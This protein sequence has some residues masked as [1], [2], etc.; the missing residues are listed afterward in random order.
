MLTAMRGFSFGD[1]SL[2]LNSWIRE[3]ILKFPSDGSKHHR[4]F[5]GCRLVLTTTFF[6]GGTMSQID[7]LF[8][9]PPNERHESATP[10]GVQN[11]K[12]HWLA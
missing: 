3:A 10:Y 12:R 9:L 4:T 6:L 11:G 8:A 1:E 2:G 5:S 7:D